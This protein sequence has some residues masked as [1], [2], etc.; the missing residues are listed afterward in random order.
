MLAKLA[1]WAKSR[2]ANVAVAVG[3]TAFSVIGYYF[4]GMPFVAEWVG[5]VAAAIA[6]FALIF[7]T[8]GYWVWSIVNAALWFYLF[9]FQYNLP[10]VGG[11]QVSYMIFSLYGI[12]MWATTKF[13]IGYDHT[14]FKDSLGTI[15]ALGIFAWSVSAYIGM[16]DY[17]FTGWW[18]VEFFAVFVSI[19]ANWMDAFK[20]K[21]NWIGW[22]IT[23]LLFG[24]L[25]WHIGLMGP[26][27]LTFL[28]QLMCCVGYYRWRKEEKQLAAEGKVKLVGGA[29]YA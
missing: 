23:N 29:Q 26:F 16:A 22:T 9:F 3:F 5:A 18:Y 25:F 15:I 14:K 17:A 21:G 12:F 2:L 7:K 28:Y 13:R 8:Q 10:M 20:Y 27:A 11:L 24:P 6:I 1:Q 19:V 4:G